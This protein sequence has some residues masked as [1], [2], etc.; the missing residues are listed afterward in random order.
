MERFIWLDYLTNFIQVKRKNEQMNKKT[1]TRKIMLSLL[2]ASILSVVFPFVPIATSA[3][4]D[5]VSVTVDVLI[6]YGNGTKVWYHGVTLAGGVTVFDATVTV[7]DVNYTDWGSWGIFIDAING[8]WNSYPY[9]WMWWYW[10]FTESRWISGPVASNFYVLNDGDIIAWY[11]EDIS[12]G[13]LLPPLSMVS[14]DIAPDILNL[15]SQGRW[16]TAYIQLPEEYNPEDIDAAT[17]LLNGTFQPILDPKYD[18][19]TNSSEYLVDY[20]G[21]GVLERMVKFNRAEVASWIF[22]DLGIQ[23]GNVTLSITGELFDGTSFDGTD[24]IKVLFPGDADDDGDVDR[25]D[26]SLLA[27][28]YG[29]N[30]DEVAYNWTTDF[31][32]D[33]SVDRYDFSIQAEYYG[34][35][36]I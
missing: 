35:R 6:D 5:A 31:N 30:I 21:D 17:I 10:D 19:V 27:A 32:E 13:P 2:I 25:Y 12:V 34:K 15:K 9:Y 11:Y 28:A 18:F 22:D 36:A 4:S 29:T 7:A 20:D 26:F 24:V 3:A 33:G 8:E 1:T 14:I 16:I 23:Y